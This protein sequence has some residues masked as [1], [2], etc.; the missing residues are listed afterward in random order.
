MSQKRP[1][2]T[3]AQYIYQQ[4]ADHIEER[5]H[6]E[7]LR[8][9]DQLRG[10]RELAA[11]YKVSYSTIHRAI[12][13]LRERQRVATLPG[14]GTFVRHPSPQVDHEHPRRIP[15]R[16]QARHMLDEQAGEELAETQN[17]TRFPVRR[18]AK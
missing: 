6:R 11:H 10:E 4:I 16:D 12:R 5:I 17:V 15:P 7:Q 2:F 3:A 14:K 1:T 8:P 9:G 13:E 18:G